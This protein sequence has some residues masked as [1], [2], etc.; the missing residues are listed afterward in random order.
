LDLFTKLYT[1]AGQQ[2]IKF[3]DNSYYYNSFLHCGKGIMRLS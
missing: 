2:N 1:D 3:G